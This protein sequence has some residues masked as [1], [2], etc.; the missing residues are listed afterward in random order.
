MESGWRADCEDEE[1]KTRSGGELVGDGGSA[2]PAPMEVS[3][4]GETPAT[5][6]AEIPPSSTSVT[7]PL[8]VQI[9]P[10][11]HSSQHHL[12][13]AETD[14]SQHIRSP[15][16]RR[17]RQ[18]RGFSESNEDDTI[19]RRTRASSGYIIFLSSTYS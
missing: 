6:A 13:P 11:S 7:E 8:S 18:Q 4:P 1:S 3:S 16:T 17:T 12:E 10:P 2:N 15:T 9:A 19:A 14:V 5:E